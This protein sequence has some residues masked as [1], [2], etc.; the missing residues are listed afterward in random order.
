MPTTLTSHEMQQL[1]D[2]RADISAMAESQNQ[3]LLD[4]LAQQ[5]TTLRAG[6]EQHASGIPECL[7]AAQLAEVIT[8][9]ESGMHT[10]MEKAGE[11]MLLSECD[12]PSLMGSLSRKGKELEESGVTLVLAPATALYFIISDMPADAQ[13]ALFTTQPLLAQLLTS[14]VLSTETAG[15]VLHEAV[16][17]MTQQAARTL[18]DRIASVIDPMLGG[19]PVQLGSMPEAVSRRTAFGDEFSAQYG[20]VTKMIFFIGGLNAVVRMYPSV[21]CDWA[22]VRLFRPA[23]ISFDG[24][25]R[26][27]LA[28][29]PH[30]PLVFNGDIEPTLIN[31]LRTLEGRRLVPH[32]MGTLSEITNITLEGGVGHQLLQL[33]KAGTANALKLTMIRQLAVSRGLNPNAIVDRYSHS[34]QQLQQLTQ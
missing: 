19:N 16:A 22:D 25:D 15:Q 9:Y 27:D 24:K 17:M 28:N 2:L 3:S 33:C 14:T 6:F 20:V 10:F 11:F 7:D 23:D 4:F 29:L 1:L 5:V 8:L 30:I 32:L 26:T 12:D 21:R 13:S 18:R 31:I 34:L